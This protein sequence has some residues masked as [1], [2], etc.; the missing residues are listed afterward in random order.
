MFPVVHGYVQMLNQLLVL[1]FS[2]Y[3]YYYST[4]PGAVQM[5]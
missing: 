3:C 2:Y 4:P 5:H 1:G